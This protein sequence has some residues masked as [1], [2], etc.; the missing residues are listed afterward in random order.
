MLKRMIDDLN[1]VTPA[2]GIL[3]ST[4]MFLYIIHNI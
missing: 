3:I 2:P 4:V 1:K